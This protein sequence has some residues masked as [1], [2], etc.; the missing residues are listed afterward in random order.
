MDN[1]SMYLEIIKTFFVSLSDALNLK[2]IMYGLIL[3][4]AGLSIAILSKRITRIFRRNN[5][6]ADNDKIMLGFKVF[7]LILLFIALL[8]IVFQI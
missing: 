8:V 3:A 6:I 4:I 2:N 1:L 5:E 7:G